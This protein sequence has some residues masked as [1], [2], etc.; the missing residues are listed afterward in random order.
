[1][2]LLNMLLNGD[3]QLFVDCLVEHF[4]VFAKFIRVLDKIYSKPQK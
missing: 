1:M 3:N 4:N 2:K